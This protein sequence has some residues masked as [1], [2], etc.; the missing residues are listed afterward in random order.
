MKKLVM[1]IL[2]HVDA[3]K[4]T[5]SESMLY[6]CGEIRTLGRVDKKDAYLDTHDLERERGI[7][8]FS[9]Q[10]I[11]DLN[12][13]RVTLLDTPGHVDFSTEM[14]RTL[15]V[16]DYAI[17]V[18]SG[19]DG[20]QGH[21]KTLWRL[22]SL[23]KIPVFLFVN[24]M[25]QPGTDKKALLAELKTKLSGACI[26]FSLGETNQFYEDIA[27]SNEALMEQF[28]ENET[29]SVE[30]IRQIIFE[31]KVFPCF[32]GS[33]LKL[34]G[35][36]EFMEG[37]T[38][39][40][41]S[42]TY[43]AEFGAQIFKISRDKQGNRLTHLKI[44]G[45]NIKVRDALTNGEWE[46]KVNEIRLYSGEKYDVVNFLEAGSICAVTGLTETNPGEGLGIATD[47]K[48]PILEPVLSYKVILPEDID[49]REM[50]PQLREIEEEEPELRIIWNEE[51]QE[52]QT[53]LMGD[54]QIEVLQ[55]L[56]KQRFGVS[57]EFDT[58]EILYKETI[59]KT[60]EGVGHFEPL[61]HYAEVLLLLEPGKRGS[62]LKY[63]TNCSEDFLPKN[64]QRLV[65]T[66]LEEKTHK[67]VLTGSPI[68]D[69]HITLLAGKHHVNHT[70]GGDFRE[71]TYRAVRQGLKEAKS[72]LLEPYY[73]FQLEVPENMVGR[74]MTD[75]ERMQGTSEIVETNKDMVI[76][77]GS[78]P[79]VNM[80]N[81]HGEVTAYTRG[82]GRL[83]CTLD[84]YKPCHNQKEVIAKVGYDSEKD[85]NNPTGSVFCTQGAGFNVSWDEVKDYMHLE[86]TLPKEI[87]VD[88]T[89]FQR[90]QTRSYSDIDEIDYELLERTGSANRGEKISWK[91]KTE[92]RKDKAIKKIKQEEIRDNY[93][94]VDGY[95]VIH[96]WPELKE[97]ADEN[98]DLARLK[99]LD[100]L[101]SYQGIRMCKIIV[102]FDAYRVPGHLETVYDY[103]NIHVVFTKEAQTAD[104]Y[105]EKFAYDHQK[106]HNI[107]VATSDGL[108]QV[109]IRG[110][111]S[112]LLSAR[113]L[114]EE[115]KQAAETLLQHYSG[116]SILDKT[117]LEEVLS[118]E[119]TKQITKIKEE[120]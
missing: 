53:Q 27:L 112:T 83:F 52:I 107:K 68:T 9:Q 109:I 80:Q 116:K 104:Q 86:S 23:Y 54:V 18:I 3:G 56:I 76:L 1:G 4:T 20:V 57:V 15:Q 110:A 69:M 60:V 101:A 17:L 7:T 72:I 73:S 95:N 97:F 37:L 64:W 92:G 28:L 111:G 26:D 88:E 84:G 62:G 77:A 45:G 5:L 75:I 96:Q 43:P 49:V 78:A 79:V 120:D 48:A 8:I 10:A 34:D 30:R 51:L 59:T 50:L 25:D 6:L 66:H 117:P 81:Y 33:A 39:Y 36:H 24:K 46:E 91:K 106:K 14:E 115:V 90:P 105:I 55:S 113:E 41:R 87:S 100:A 93:L 40:T 16:L 32:F 98:M 94:L 63:S 47:S 108:Q 12:D 99:L 119:V 89:I 70:Q 61:R 35:I 44:V 2:A 22:L 103:H 67:G 102:V 11:F 65:L 13:I 58:G 71:A 74:A 85:R 82:L 31:R 19:A 42:S 114:R 118:K 38:K 21:T 29:I